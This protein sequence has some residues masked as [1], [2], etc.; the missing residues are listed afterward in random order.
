YQSYQNFDPYFHDG[1]DL[2]SDSLNQSV[3]LPFDSKLDY[4]D[5]ACQKFEGN[6]YSQK[7]CA[8]CFKLEDDLNF[9]V[10]HLKPSSIPSEIKIGQFYSKGTHL[11]TVLRW[12]T[13]KDQLNYNHAHISIFRVVKTDNDGNPIL[14]FLNPQLFFEPIADNISPTITEIFLITQ[15][16][17]GFFTKVWEK[18]TDHKITAGTEYIIGLETY[19][20]IGNSIHKLMPYKVS[21]SIDNGERISALQFDSLPGEGDKQYLDDIFIK[22]FSHSDEISTRF[23]VDLS[24]STTGS[25]KLP[26]E[27]GKHNI[28]VKVED[29]A[30]NAAVSNFEWEIK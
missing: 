20:Y 13:E 24:F 3:E 21:Y 11:G 10:G 16:N 1:I 5:P 29:Y 6:F 8:L 9:C 14:K 26:T 23:S 17:Y 25:R 19:D 30:G 7:Q 2:V 22:D 12:I 28:E 15:K 4:I 18:S 27:L